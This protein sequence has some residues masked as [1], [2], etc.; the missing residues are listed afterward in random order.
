MTLT[1]PEK[2]YLDRRRRKASQSTEAHARG[3]GL[4]PYENL[5]K[6]RTEHA[7]T[8]YLSA[9][10]VRDVTPQEWCYVLRRRAK[11]TQSELAKRLGMS[12]AWVV[13][14]EEGTGDCSPLVWYWTNTHNGHSITE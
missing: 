12:R 6:G 2:F 8:R 4:H 5:E 7:S 10:K 14:M 1:R 11:V 9:P 13:A 3:V